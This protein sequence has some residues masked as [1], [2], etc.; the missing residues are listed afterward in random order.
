M[1]VNKN[2]PGTLEDKGHMI[3]K[4]RENSVDRNGPTTETDIWVRQNF[5]K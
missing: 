5:F 2:L 4:P 1:T 3:K